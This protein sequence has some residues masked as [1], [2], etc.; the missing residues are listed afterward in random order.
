[1]LNIDIGGQKHKRTIDGKWKVLDVR[2]GADYKHNLNSG[3]PIPLESDSVDNIYCSHTIEHLDI[4]HITYVLKDLCRILK[5]K[6]KMRIIVPDLDVA[7][8]L[9]NKKK[10]MDRKYCYKPKDIPAVPMGYLTAWFST[11]GFGHKI[12][13][14]EELL[15]EYLKRTKFKNIKRLSYNNCSKV[16][17]DKDYDIYEGWCLYIEVEK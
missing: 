15:V 6:G 9:Y 4:D 1:M 12:G 8:D 7:I 2:D 5:P 13:F 16:F 3:K 14:N 17:K 10:L 11:P